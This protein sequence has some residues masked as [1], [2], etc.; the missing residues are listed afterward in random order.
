MREDFGSMQEITKI[1]IFLS[2]LVCKLGIGRDCEELGSEDS[3][4]SGSKDLKVLDLDLTTNWGCRK[5]IVS[6]V[7]PSK[8]V[9]LHP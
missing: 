5:P 2:K 6:T 7:T 9:P 8:P 1:R 4:W 3:F